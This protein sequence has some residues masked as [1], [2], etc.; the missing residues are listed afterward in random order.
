[1]RALL[2]ASVMVCLCPDAA[3]AQ[4]AAERNVTFG[5]FGGGTLPVATGGA[6]GLYESGAHA[7]A[8]AEIKTPLRWL[9]IRVDGSYL[10]Q[11][12]VDQD[13]VDGNGQLL[14][15]LRT[16]VTFLSGSAGLIVRIPNLR[17]VVQP[18]ALA[19]ATTFRAQSRL[20]SSGGLSIGPMTTGPV[21]RSHGFNAGLGLEAP[22]GQARIFVEA[23]YMRVSNGVGQLPLSVGVKY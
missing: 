7:G 3:F 11:A 2:F 19:G 20:T 16:R 8:L 21:V 23:R 12:T 9:G 5:A 4:R 15:Q 10:R 6:Q 22:A 18:Y 1:M 14:G 17:S 13:V